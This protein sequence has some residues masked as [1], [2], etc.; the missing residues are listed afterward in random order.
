ML[1]NVSSSLIFPFSQQPSYG[2]TQS[3][4]PFAQGGHRSIEAVSIA[5]NPLSTSANWQCYNYLLAPLPKSPE[6]APL[7]SPSKTS[8]RKEQIIEK[9]S[10]NPEGKFVSSTNSQNISPNLSL[11]KKNQKNT[12]LDE[13]IKSQR[14]NN[15]IAKRC[16]FEKNPLP[17]ETSPLGQQ[18]QSNQP[19]AP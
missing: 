6:K 18:I 13:K 8:P 5:S 1:N 15:S 14:F 17:N 19:L 11:I 16:L 4:R 9:E 3:E 10:S 12:S 7:N 2:S